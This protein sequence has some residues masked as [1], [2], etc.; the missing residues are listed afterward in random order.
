MSELPIAFGDV[1]I[2]TPRL[3]LRRLSAEDIPALFRINAD[4]LVARYGARAAM[5]EI[6]EAQ[7]L[8]ESVEEGYRTGTFLQLGLERRADLALLGTCVLLRLDGSNRR[9]EL[10]YLLGSEYWGAG[11][12]AEALDAFV[13]YAFEELDLLRLEADIDPRNAAS[14]RSLLR[15]G[16]K[17]EGHM[18]ERWLVAGELSDTGF[19]GLLRR[20]WRLDRERKAQ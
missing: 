14:E 10:G 12:M 11:W 5:T 9:A 1:S 16:F 2:S 4:P 3:R 8:L 20:E 19:Y 18:R 13:Q 6:G 17:K 7:R 15:L